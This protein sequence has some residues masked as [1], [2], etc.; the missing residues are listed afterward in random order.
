L[1]AELQHHEDVIDTYEQA[2]DIASQIVNLEFKQ[3]VD[4]ILKN[5]EADMQRIQKFLTQKQEEAKL[6]R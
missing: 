2:K 4:R 3:N 5:M 6:A 1:Q